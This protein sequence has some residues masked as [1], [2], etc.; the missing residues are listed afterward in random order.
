MPK[1]RADLGP[2]HLAR[3][4]KL[5]HALQLTALALDGLLDRRQ[6]LQQAFR[7]Q[8]LVSGRLRRRH[9]TGNDFITES[10]ALVADEDA[11]RAGDQLSHVML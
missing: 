11:G 2:A 8:L 6:P 4:Q 1:R 7:R 9:T 10:D 3:P 5:D